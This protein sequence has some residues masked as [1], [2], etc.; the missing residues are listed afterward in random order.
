MVRCY[1]CTCVPVIKIYLFNVRR[2]TFSKKKLCFNI[3]SLRPI[4]TARLEENSCRIGLK[5]NPQKWNRMKISNR[6]DEGLRVREN[7]VEEVDSFIYLGTQ[8]TKDGG[9]TLDIK[10][11]RDST[12]V[13]KL[14]QAPI[15]IWRARN[16]M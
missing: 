5:L 15:K 11:S 10:K 6:N 4:K 12:G 16:I 7:M 9:A 1:T 13:C 2:V 14:Q 3:P 8:V